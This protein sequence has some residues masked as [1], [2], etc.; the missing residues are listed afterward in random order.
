MDGMISLF[1]PMNHRV[2]LGKENS[3]LFE[4][5]AVKALLQQL[6]NKLLKTHFSLSI[7]LRRTLEV[8][9]SDFGIYL[10][11]PKCNL[12]SKKSLYQQLLEIPSSL[13]TFPPK[14]NHY[15]NH[16]L[17]KSYRRYRM[18][19]TSFLV[20]VTLSLITTASATVTDDTFFHSLLKRQAPGT[21]AYQC[22]LDCGN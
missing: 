2:S 17:E 3:N 9:A 19:F 18:L 21:P 7:I 5:T 6:G 13:S 22:H 15:T 14:S 16:H 8:A 1:F 10:A 11:G 12:K 4:F 20:P